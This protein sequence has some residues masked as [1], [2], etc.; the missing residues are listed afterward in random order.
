[1]AD[2]IMLMYNPIDISSI[3]KQDKSRTISCSY[4]DNSSLRSIEASIESLTQQTHKLSTPNYNKHNIKTFHKV[5][6]SLEILLIDRAGI[7][8]VLEPMLK[9][10]VHKPM[11]FQRIKSKSGKLISQFLFEASNLG[12]SYRLILLDKKGNC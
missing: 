11:Q 3:N 8:I 4:D 9:T 1:M 2:K 5:V 7:I 12:S 10:H 6:L